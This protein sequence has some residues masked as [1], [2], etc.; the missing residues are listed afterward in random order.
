MNTPTPQQPNDG[1]EPRHFTFMTTEQII[2]EGEAFRAKMDTI[3]EI[4]DKCITIKA[5]YPYRIELSRIPNYHAL[6]QWTLHLAGK[7]WMDG[8][9]IKEFIS[10]VCQEKGWDLYSETF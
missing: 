4:D 6:C 1:P 9:L 8:A 5:S 10:R 3:F 2:Q 7:G